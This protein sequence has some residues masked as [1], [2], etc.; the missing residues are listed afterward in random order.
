[1]FVRLDDSQVSFPPPPPPP[2]SHLQTS[3]TT[4]YL[5]NGSDWQVFIF[6]PKVPSQYFLLKVT[7]K[8]TQVFSFSLIAFVPFVMEM[9]YRGKVG[10][11]QRH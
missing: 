10:A 11:Y 4:A 8:N 1:M 7:L 6:V 3:Q 9:A 5:F 2:H